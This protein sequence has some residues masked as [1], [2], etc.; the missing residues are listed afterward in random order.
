MQ[1]VWFLVCSSF[2][3]IYYHITKSNK[4]PSVHPLHKDIT[5]RTNSK[6]KTVKICHATD[7]G[8]TQLARWLAAEQAKN[9]GFYGGDKDYNLKSLLMVLFSSF[10][11]L[12]DKMKSFSTALELQIGIRKKISRIIKKQMIGQ[13][14]TVNQQSVKFLY[15]SI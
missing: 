8:W 11:I 14:I 3:Q 4:I 10:F 2:Q 9:W 13:I 5:R 7:K 15:H 12:R 1:F 6:K